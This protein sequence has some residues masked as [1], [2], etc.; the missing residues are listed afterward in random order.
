MKNEKPKPTSFICA[1]PNFHCL[2]RKSIATQE[3][4]STKT[5]LESVKPV[6]SMQREVGSCRGSLYNSQQPGFPKK[7]N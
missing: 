2:R 1:D 4:I 5:S 3:A 6:D 7:D